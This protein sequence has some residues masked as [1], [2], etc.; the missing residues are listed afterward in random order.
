MD[1][2]EFLTD[3]SKCTDHHFTDLVRFWNGRSAYGT[4]LCQK[5]GTT[6]KW[7]YDFPDVRDAG[8]T[9]PY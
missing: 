5:C 7:Q 1:E 4:K 2:A 6:H 8:E 9:V 3:P